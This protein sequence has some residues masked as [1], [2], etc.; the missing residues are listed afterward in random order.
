MGYVTCILANWHE[1]MVTYTEWASQAACLRRLRAA[2]KRI[3][4][5]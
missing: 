4:L 2:I 1:G 3:Q 5:Q